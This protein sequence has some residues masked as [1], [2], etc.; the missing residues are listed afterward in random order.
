MASLL[1]DVLVA[2]G[3]QAEVAVDVIEARLAVRNFDPDGIL[4]DIS[5]G[6]GPSGL[7]LARVLAHQRPDIAIIFLTKHSD[8][9]T[10]GI[11][12]ADL[13]AGC[14]FLRKDRVRDTEFLLESIEA[15][16]TDQARGVRHD[17]DPGKP[18][19]ALTAKQVDVLRMMAT[20]YT[21]EHI[22]RVKGVAVSTVERWTVEIFKEL[23][24]D[25]KGAVNS[26]VEAVRQFIAAAGIPER[27]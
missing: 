23:G 14:G 27:L 24:I 12:D 16:M 8:P 21:N 25:G 13:P 3:F 26:R 5:L 15:V 20:G 22:A 19:A 17:M 9:R 18:L 10:A 11:D 6:D 4:M 2:N 1:A 7:D